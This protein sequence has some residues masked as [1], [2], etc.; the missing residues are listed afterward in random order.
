MK[1]IDKNR[2]GLVFGI[3]AAV[4]HFVWALLVAIG[5]G[6][7]ALNWIIPLHFVN[8]AFAVFEFDISSAVVLIGA[9]FVGGYLCGY[10]LALLWNMFEKK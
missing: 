7:K 2:L 6:E 10:I 4:I 3:F 5:V 9:G 1:E 8:N